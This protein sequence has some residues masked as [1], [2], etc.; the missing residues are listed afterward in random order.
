MK[1]LGKRA[2]TLLLIGIII[3]SFGTMTRSVVSISSDVDDFLKGFGLSVMVGSLISDW[4]TTQ[5]R[6]EHKA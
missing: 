3:M 6:E 1:P 5:R 4:N 2:R